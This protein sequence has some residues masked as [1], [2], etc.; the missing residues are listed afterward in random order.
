MTGVGGVT[1]IRTDGS[2][3]TSIG[4]RV[5]IAM[6]PDEAGDLLR[7]LVG[8]VGRSGR[9][10]S[11]IVE[12]ARRPVTGTRGEGSRAM[13]TPVVALGESNVN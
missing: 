10:L 6:G 12:R 7:D 13:G 2:E 8:S 3:G 4:G 9:P 11:K 1:V 5:G